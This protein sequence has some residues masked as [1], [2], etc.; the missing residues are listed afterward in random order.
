[1]P[2]KPALILGAR[3]V[4]TVMSIQRAQRR[5]A[6]GSGDKT[7][8]DKINDRQAIGKSLGKSVSHTSRSQATERILIV[9]A[10][11]RGH[12]FSVVAFLQPQCV[13]ALECGNFA[14]QHVH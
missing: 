12:S 14:E 11:K 2:A 8:C 5:V 4:C 10:T 9:L 13:F 3:M 6:T 7:L 1:M